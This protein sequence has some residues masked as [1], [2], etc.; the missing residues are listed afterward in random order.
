MGRVA[1]CVS[2]KTNKLS[3]FS[4]SLDNDL[5]Q[6]DEISERSFHKGQSLLYRSYCLLRLLDSL[7]WN[8]MLWG[9][10]SHVFE[11]YM[12]NENRT[13]SMNVPSTYGKTLD[14]PSALRTNLF[15]GIFCI[16]YNQVRV[17]NPFGEQWNFTLFC[18]LVSIT[19]SEHVKM[20][21][22]FH[23]CSATW[24]SKSAIWIHTFSLRLFYDIFGN[25]FTKII[26]EDLTLIC[27]LIQNKST[28]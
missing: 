2:H 18:L 28:W 20:K 8:Y 5:H 16:F 24:F 3:F 10:W 21:N 26:E 14:F 17:W 1:T 15:S 27:W 4:A 11:G 6:F 7:T 22:H 9:N 25:N 23:I 13:G 12:I 19:K